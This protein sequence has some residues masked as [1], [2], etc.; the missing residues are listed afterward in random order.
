ME[1]SMDLITGAHFQMV[2]TTEE[3]TDCCSPKQVMMVLSL[4]RNST[5]GRQMVLKTGTS[6][7]KERWK[8]STSERLSDGRLDGLDEGITVADRSAEGVDDGT[9]LSDGEL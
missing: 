4:P 5:M 7:A 2:L 1:P 9:I 3:R 6:L 8:E